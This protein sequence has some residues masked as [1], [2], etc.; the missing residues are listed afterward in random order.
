LKFSHVIA[1]LGLATTF[2]FSAPLLASSEDAWKEFR[3]NVQ[4]G[5]ETAVGDR[6]VK[7]TYTVD[8]FGTDSYG[9]AIARGPSKYDK[10][11]HVIV[12]VFDKKTLKTEATEELPQ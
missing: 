4:K 1:G 11:P 12:C 8:P 3:A 5:C 9:V 10:A 2:A 7:P 6:L